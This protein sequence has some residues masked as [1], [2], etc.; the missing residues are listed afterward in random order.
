MHNDLTQIQSL[1]E[2]D[3][4][5][6]AMAL[7]IV[8]DLLALPEAPK[9]ANECATQQGEYDVHWLRQM[10]VERMM[11]SDV[12]V[13]TTVDDFLSNADKICTFIMGDSPRADS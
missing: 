9:T 1:L 5:K 2:E 7:R 13:A 10:I 6:V 11:A 12:I 3:E 4:P 8:E